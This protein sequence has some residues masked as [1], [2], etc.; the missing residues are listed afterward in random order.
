MRQGNCPAGRCGL[1][2]A[3]SSC[4]RSPLL[5]AGVAPITAG[6]MGRSPHT[7]IEAHWRTMLGSCLPAK[8]GDRRVGP[9]LPRAPDSAR[10]PNAVRSGGSVRLTV[11]A[12]EKVID[13]VSK[14]D[15]LPSAPFTPG[16]YCTPCAVALRRLG[17]SDDPKIVARSR[18]ADGLC[19][20]PSRHHQWPPRGRTPRALRSRHTGRDPE[21]SA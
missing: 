1:E 20:D 5:V 16:S 12:E 18:W 6:V 8:P 13:L 10:E 19:Q 3:P 7:R 21:A 14:R 17:A 9:A 11:R 15:R 4:L 2:P